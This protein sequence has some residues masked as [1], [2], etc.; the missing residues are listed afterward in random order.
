M[1]QRRSDELLINYSDKDQIEDRPTAASSCVNAIGC[2]KDGWSKRTCSR[3][4]CGRQRAYRLGMATGIWEAMQPASA[5]AVLT[6]NGSVEIASATADIGPDLYDDDLL[7]PSCSAY[8]WR[9]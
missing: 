7:P 5:R 1:R 9:T 6:A 2:G 4:R 8:R 3:A